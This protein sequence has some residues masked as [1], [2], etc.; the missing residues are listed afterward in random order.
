MKI[1]LT[2]TIHSRIKSDHHPSIQS[3][4][5]NAQTIRRC[6]GSTF[7]PFFKQWE[8]MKFMIIQNPPY[9]YAYV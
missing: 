5:I 8:L 4:I 6:R 7:S 3:L 1:K 2:I 9:S